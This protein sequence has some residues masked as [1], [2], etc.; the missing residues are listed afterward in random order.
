[1]AMSLKTA[2]SPP[3]KKRSL[4]QQKKLLLRYL[5][6]FHLS[7]TLA[8]L[9]SSLQQLL[10]QEFGS[11]EVRFSVRDVRK[12]WLTYRFPEPLSG[13]PIRRGMGLS[14]KVVE[15]GKALLFD[16]PLDEPPD[17][18]SALAAP[19]YRD[20]R[21][22]GTVEL[23]E[24]QAGRSFAEEDRQHLEILTPHMAIALNHFVLVEESERKSRIEGRLREVSR[25]VNAT[26]NLDGILEAMLESLRGLVPYDEAAIFLFGEGDEI[27][28]VAALGY[29][30]PSNGALDARAQAIFRNWKS[31]PVV[32]L[33]L[34]SDDCSQ[35]L[36][37][38][39]LEAQSEMIIPLQTGDALMGLF[40]LSNAQPDCYAASD[41]ELLEAF[42]RLAAQ[43]VERARLHQSL[44]EK[45]QLEQE[46]K[47]AREIQVRFLP[48][49][50]PRIRGV[51]LAARN[52]ASRMVSG[53]YY[54]VIHIVDDQWGLVVGDVSGKGISAGMI[55]SAFRA[56]LLAEIRNNFNIST[57]LAKVNRLIWETTDPNLFVT[58]FYGVF[59]EQNRVLTYSNAGHNPGLL[60]RASGEL[61]RLEAG[62]TVLGAFPDSV[63]NE[64]R[65][66]IQ[67]G[68]LLLLYTDGLSESRDA[69]GEELGIAGVE[70][71]LRRLGG[72]SATEVAESLIQ[73][74]TLMCANGAPEDDVTLMVFKAG[75]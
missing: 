58:A 61:E 18:T 38:I 67:P 64:S 60:L 21:V 36:P 71:L 13:K 75:V 59:D 1:M 42:G 29:E 14:G 27:E 53:D 52:L 46:V 43:A 48:T 37:R 35:A 66:A 65:I 74:V 11:V 50:M 51:D 72:R 39:H 34:C 69:A 12:N 28:R 40:A 8:E 16:R 17:F 23:I 30:S 54:D 47:I 3:G 7:E 19:L 49:V 63:Y 73:E 32:P 4:K 25:K 68:D 22:L 57:I 26:L 24:R 10:Q 6:A 2:D 44:L 56:S 9:F 20:H 62:G 41:L 55:M 33:L 70:T 15:E 31:S 45:S 5:E